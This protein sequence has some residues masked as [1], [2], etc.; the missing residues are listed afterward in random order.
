MLDEIIGRDPSIQKIKYSLPSLAQNSTPLIII[1]EGGVGK[2]FLAAHIHAASP[3]SLRAL[4]SL[5]FS[6]LPER[7]QRINLLGGEPP[8]L[9]TTRRSVLEL[10]TTVILKH[11]DC[12]NSFLQNSL[13]E[14]LQ[15]SLVR[16]PGS[17]ES[18]PV[19]A[20][21][22]FTFRKPISALKKNH[23][24][25][26]LHDFL[27]SLPRIHIPPLR[28][29]V[30]DIALLAQFYGSKLYERY[31]SNQEIIIRG[32]D[33]DGRIDPNLLEFLKNQKWEDNIRDLMTLIYNL[34]LFPLSMEF[35]NRPKMEL[36]KMI[37]MIDELNE[38]SLPT[39]LS[40]IEQYIVNL[41]VQKL[42]QNKTKA[43]QLLG[44]SDRAIR[45]WLNL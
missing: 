15:S 28:E 22:I 44:V 40:F 36:I 29:R 23:L 1:G 26:L 9:T 35:L 27:H 3:L 2:S 18:H 20:R 8:D 6:T 32:I 43:A 13:V 4:E 5:N 33:K 16:R 38:F 11:I 21:V 34:T 19:S 42:N 24:S 10:K 37:L 41:A 14:I 25:P 7:D 17:S 31:G 12:A 39:K 30:D 45:R